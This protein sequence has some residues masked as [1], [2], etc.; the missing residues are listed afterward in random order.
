MRQ[1]IVFFC[2]DLLVYTVYFFAFLGQSAYNAVERRM[3]PLSRDLTGLIL[4]HAFYGSHLDGQGKTVDEK[5][6]ELN[7]AKAGTVL[8]KFSF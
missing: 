2:L 1:V 4:P 6:E 3:A 7:F 5:L 8:G